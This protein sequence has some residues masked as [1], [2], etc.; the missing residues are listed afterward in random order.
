MNKRKLFSQLYSKVKESGNAR[1]MRAYNALVKEFADLAKIDTMQDNLDH[2]NTDDADYADQIKDELNM[3]KNYID[4][5]PSD[6]MS[7][8]D[9]RVKGSE[10]SSIE[11]YMYDKGFKPSDT[12]KFDNNEDEVKVGDF[13][14]KPVGIQTTDHGQNTWIFI[15]RE[16]VDALSEIV[17]FN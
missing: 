11:D 6:I 16:D 9:K 15:K 3:I 13:D 5:S 10:Y 14:G 1:A 7:L 2:I 4:A 12:K 17:E 8:S